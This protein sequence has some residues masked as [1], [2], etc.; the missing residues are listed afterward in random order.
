MKYLF[1]KKIYSLVMA[2]IDVMGCLI[3]FP[4]KK[5]APFDTVS[6]KKILFVRLDHLGDVWLA[7]AAAKIIKEN[8]PGS[9]ITYLVSSMAA[10]ILD[11]H[12]FIDEKIF[13]D[14]SWF[15]RDRTP[16]MK[17][18]LVSL[19]NDLR[20]RQFDVALLPRGDFRENL[21]TA[22]AGIPERIGF[23]VTGG[24]F[25]LTR[26]IPY[27]RSCH[28][29]D[30]TKDILKFLGARS[31]EL[32]PQL[33]FSQNDDAIMRQREI[34]LALD[35]HKKW[36]AIQMSA[37]SR[38]KEWPLQHYQTLVETL[39]SKRPNFQ[40]LLFGSPRDQERLV[41]QGNAADFF[42]WVSKNNSI[43]NLLGKI[44]LKE[45]LLI[46]RRCVLFIGPDT[47]PTHMA[48]SLATNTIFLYSGTNVYDEWKP[49]DERAFVM[50]QEVPCAPCALTECPVAG[51]PCMSKIT[52]EKV[53]SRISEII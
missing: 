42:E 15:S 9:R 2:L 28:E 26:E 10:P 14:A 12:P 52:P 7:S 50:R 34:A 38:A 44:T 35:P 23:G 41:A 22:M 16:K 25:L 11:N 30:R 27:R 48:S 20:Q 45:L 17:R 31:G 18:T 4:F 33:F 39:I 51:H 43:A 47:G 46:A 36:V 3:F 49:L 37:G 19:I 13:F 40:I 5:R 6:S 1:R 29:S 32:R 53:F 21:I 8:L 24:G